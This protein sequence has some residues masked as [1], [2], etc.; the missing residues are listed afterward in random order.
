M[1]ARAEADRR[2]FAETLACD[3]E[4]PFALRTASSRY[5]CLEAV[6]RSETTL[7]A[8]GAL[9]DDGDGTEN[10]PPR[11][12]AKI[13]LALGLLAILA[14]R[15]QIVAAPRRVRWSRLGFRAAWPAAFAV[16][17]M[18]VC[19]IQLTPALPLPVELPARVLACEAHDDAFVLWLELAEATPALHSAIERELFRRHRRLVH[20]QRSART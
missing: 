6:R 16:D 11:I 19:S 8:L 3:D 12:E 13:D 10:V 17:A 4:F 15:E 7:R 5:E 9:D 18:L 20:E 1:I 14:A 2:L